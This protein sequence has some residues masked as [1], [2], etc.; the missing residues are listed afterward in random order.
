MPRTPIDRS[1]GFLLHDIARLLRKRYE[2]RA[3]PLGLTRAQWQVLAHLQ[4][5]EGI[6]QSRLA[7]LLELEPITVA[8]LIDRME[9]AGLVERRDDPADRRAH[10]LYLTGRARPLLERCRPVADA[11]YA[12]AFAGIANGKREYLIDLLVQV[13]GNLSE[14]RGEEEGKPAP[15]PQ[16]ETAETSL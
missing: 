9:E 13:R 6:N 16:R 14:R 12:E 11:I 5:S 15:A 7:E 10:L 8:R 2:Q 1:F 4:R 3:R